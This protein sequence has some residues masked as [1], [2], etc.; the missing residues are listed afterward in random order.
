MTG[1]SRQVCQK[2]HT[3]IYWLYWQIVLCQMG[4]LPIKIIRGNCWKIIISDT[5]QLEWFMLL[6]IKRNIDHYSIYYP[7]YCNTVPG[8]GTN[9]IAVIR[10][11]CVTLKWICRNGETIISLARHY[12]R[13]KS[14]N[15]R[16][17]HCLA[18]GNKC[19]WMSEYHDDDFKYTHIA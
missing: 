13:Q 2:P 12:I 17:Q 6:A 18:S 4:P 11:H 15:V 5:F 10:T 7:L 16:A 9:T 19:T 3:S 1:T 8:V 14:K